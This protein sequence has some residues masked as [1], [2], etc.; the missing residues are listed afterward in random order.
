MRF[1]VLSSGSKAN[2]VYLESKQARI[3]IDCGLS[4]K[5]IELRLGR[6]G[7]NPSTLDA[8]LVTHEH[9]DHVYGIAVFSRRYKVPLLANK[10]TISA[11]PSYFAFEKFATGQSFNFKDLKILPFPVSHDA[12]DPVGFRIESE[13][14]VYAQATDLGELTDPVVAALKGAHSLLIESNHDSDLLWNC[15]Y[16]FELKQRICSKYGHLSN[17]SAADLLLKVSHQE[18]QNVV[19]GHISENS[20]RPEL[21]FKSAQLASTNLDLAN[22][23]C[24]NPYQETDLLSVAS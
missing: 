5:Q 11:L 10:R 19:L 14:L 15:H 13:G 17:Q 1:S 23:Q 3:L 9:R 6:L 4:A 24:A 16:P 7:I 18:L 2:C 20:N 8:I 22:L 12:L 21:A